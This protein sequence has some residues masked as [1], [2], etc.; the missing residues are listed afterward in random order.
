MT[1]LFRIFSELLGPGRD[2]G[3]GLAIDEYRLERR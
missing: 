2:R 3:V 1:R